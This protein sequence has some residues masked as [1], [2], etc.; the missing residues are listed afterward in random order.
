MRRITI[1][2]SS[3][4]M[5]TELQ[6]LPPS[7]PARWS[8]GSGSTGWFR[9]RAAGN[10]RNFNPCSVHPNL[11]HRQMPLQPHAP[12]SWQ[13]MNRAGIHWHSMC[14]LHSRSWN[15]PPPEPS[16]HG[17]H[18]R[19]ASTHASI[20]RL[21]FPVAIECRCVSSPTPAPC[22]LHGSFFSPG[23]IHLPRHTPE[24]GSWFSVSIHP[25]SREGRSGFH[26]SHVGRDWGGATPGWKRDGQRFGI[27][28]TDA[29]LK[30]TRWS[31]RTAQRRTLGSDRD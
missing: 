6:G 5:E 18:R 19:M 21:S 10:K 31:R 25:P 1:N 30:H 28:T 13:S 12:R 7:V 27:G 17:G 20:W 29:H 16:G 22:F 15:G 8:A 3:S 14:N 4:S 24:R 9:G 26:T 23:S 2:T 11:R